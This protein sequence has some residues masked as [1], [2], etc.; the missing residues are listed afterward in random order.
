VAAFS[1]TLLQL[2][3]DASLRRSLGAQGRQRLDDHFDL[4]RFRQ[5]IRNLVWS[6]LPQEIHQPV[7]NIEL[8]TS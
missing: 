8:T 2:S 7:A 4:S 6:H 5:A 1:E 3:A